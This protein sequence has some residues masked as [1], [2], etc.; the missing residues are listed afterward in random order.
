[1]KTFKVV[2]SQMMSC[3]DE[4]AFSEW[5]NDGGTGMPVTGVNDMERGDGEW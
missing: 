2:T 3:K 4:V 5:L 1:M